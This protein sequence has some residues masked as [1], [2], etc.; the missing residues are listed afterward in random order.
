MS[1]EVLLERRPRLARGTGLILIV[2]VPRVLQT[3]GMENSI[4]VCDATINYARA[5]ETPIS[6]SPSDS[7]TPIADA[8]EAGFV[9]LCAAP[10]ALAEVLVATIDLAPLAKVADPTDLVPVALAGPDAVGG[11]TPP[12]TMVRARFFVA[13]VGAAKVMDRV[14]AIY[15]ADRK[16]VV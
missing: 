2:T 7:E 3:V 11:V 16:S 5:A 13:A 14:P 8:A 1:R 15:W 6:P 12:G 9:A 10:A 4:C